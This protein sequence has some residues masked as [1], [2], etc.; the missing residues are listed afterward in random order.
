MGARGAN[1]HACDFAFLI[2]QTD[3]GKGNAS[4]PMRWGSDMCLS[5]V[6][7]HVAKCLMSSRKGDNSVGA[8]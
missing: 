5:S 3:R 4:S 2:F 8:N 7:Y 6:A 1:L